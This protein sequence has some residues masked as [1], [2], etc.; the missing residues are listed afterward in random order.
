MTKTNARLTFAVMILQAA[1]AGA[2]QAVRAAETAPMTLSDAVSYALSHSPTVAAQRATLAQAE[3]TLAVAKTNAYPVVS[4]ELQNYSQKSSHYEG[5]FAVIG[6]TP[7]QVFSQNTAQIGTNYTVQTGGAAFMQL[8]A[9]RA[10]V[11]Q[12]RKT[13][14]DDENH[15]ATSVANAY[16]AVVQKASIVTVDK[17]DLAYQRAL[18]NVAKAKERAGVSAGVDVLRAEASQA[19]SASDLVGARADVE[20]A[21]ETLALTIGAPL[22]QQFVFP[23]VIAAPPLPDKPVE[24]LEAIAVQTRPDVA[25]AND[26]LA[27]AEFTRN[28]WSRELYP[29]VAIGAAF[30]N[31]FSPTNVNYGLN[32]AGRL[33]PLPRVGAPGFWTI[34]A[35]STFTLPFEDYG[36]RHMERVSDDAQIDSAQLAL[37]QAQS[38]VEIDVR[39]SYRAAQTALAQVDYARDEARLGT[40]SARVAQL[41][42]EHGLV[43]LT[44]VMQAQQ[45]SVVAQSDFIN[46]RIAYVDAVV[47]LRVAL[48]VYNAQSAV[49]DLQ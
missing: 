32:S 24:E 33:V 8:A 41:Q 21:R 14:A 40:E 15:V 45:Q 38:R 2:P 11:D 30:G 6:L 13:L 16:F 43:A 31:Q 34:S 29:Q 20:N 9:D 4:G 35:V 47:K 5:N 22:D 10:Q 12:A 49:A 37:T 7:T 3:H 25:A 46:A 28:G 48:G 27:S 36:A 23:R 19:R 44:D 26:A 42:Y 17:A 1:L 39:Q 18:V